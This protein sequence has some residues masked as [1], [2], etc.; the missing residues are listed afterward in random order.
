MSD[1]LQKIGGGPKCIRGSDGI[2]FLYGS[3]NRGLGQGRE[4]TGFSEVFDNASLIPGARKEIDS[5]VFVQK[6]LHVL[7]KV[8]FLDGCFLCR[9][10]LSF[11][12]VIY[13][14]LQRARVCGCHGSK[15][16]KREQYGTRLCYKL[17]ICK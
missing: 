16:G 17:S 1:L 8:Q 2:D 15:G 6:C 9:Y 10:L 14:N 13:H 3:S 7:L 4:V 5:C 12:L 11:L